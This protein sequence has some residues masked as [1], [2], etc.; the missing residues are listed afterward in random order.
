[1]ELNYKKYGDNDN[2]VI[3]V[4]GLFGMLDNWHNIARKL[5]ENY[6]VYTVD[7]RNHG[8]SPHADEMDYDLISNDLY[9]F[10]N[11]H[12][13]TSASFVGHSMGGK[14]VMK[15]A[16]LFPGIINKLCVVDIAPKKYKPEH[17]QYFKAMFNL[18]VA[19]LKS[20]GEAEKRL[21]EMIPDTGIRLFLL[22]NLHR[23]KEGGF[24]WKFNLQ[25]IYD[26]YEAIIDKVSL[27]W[28][29]SNPSLFI[30]GAKSNYISEE[31]EDA[32]YEMFPNAEFTSIPDA[33]HWVHAENPTDFF[34]TLN[35]FLS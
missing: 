12:H 18:P 7:L 16:D 20:R 23:S 1:L 21:A 13:I 26:N 6:T 29:F 8:G 9:H 27:D 19:E 25:G 33:G 35:E 15:L 17:H 34:N 14:A 11:T 31:D 30:K 4:H 24:H 10:T 2:V 28:P 5:S 3:I 32:I 22:K